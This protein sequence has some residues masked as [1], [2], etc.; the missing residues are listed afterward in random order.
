MNYSMS[1]IHRVNIEKILQLFGELTKVNVAFI[2]DTLQLFDRKRNISDSQRITSLFSAKSL[3]FFPLVTS[4]K[5]TGMFIANIKTNSSDIL[6][7]YQTSLETTVREV[8]SAY[9]QSIEILSPLRIDQLNQNIA[10]FQFISSNYHGQGISYNKTEKIGPKAEIENLNN[11]LLYINKN[12]NQKLPLTD[13]SKHTFLSLAY[14]SRLFKEFFLVNFSDYVRLRKIAIAQEKLILTKKSI[15]KIS[16]EIGFSRASYFNR[17]FK[18]ETGI[19]PLQFRKK[20][21]GSKIYTINRDIEWKNNASV[22]AISQQYFQSK[23]VSIKVKSL[24][25]SPYISSIGKLSTLSSGNNGWVYLIDGKQ[26][27][28]L[29][30]NMYVK[31]KS[32]IQWIYINL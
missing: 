9:F 11:A 24:N 10:L 28:V 31:N 30:G 32:V 7:L 3:I 17:V 6:K 29:P 13:V 4:Q 20:Y 2:D 5:I 23:G 19:T 18:E 1:S 27:N 21:K 14:L 22:Y 25:G 26:P 8:L 12:I 16:K 15:N